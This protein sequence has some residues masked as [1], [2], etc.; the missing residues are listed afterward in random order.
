MAKLGTQIENPTVLGLRRTWRYAGTPSDGAAGTLYNV[1]DIGDLLIDTTGKKL[2][3][4]RGTK[5]SPTWTEVTGSGVA[6]D[7]VVGNMAA[8]G[9]STANA[10]G[11]GPLAA[12]VDHVHKI[13]THDHSDATKGSAIVL[14]ALGAGIFT[15]DATGRA[16]F[17]TNFL[18][19]TKLADIIAI[20]AMTNAFLVAKVA[21]DALDSAFCDAA[22]AANA[23]AA[24][25]AGR[26]PFA[27]G[28]W[29]AAKLA[30]DAVETLKI[31]DLNV[32]TAKLAVGIISADAPGRALFAAG[33]F[34]AATVLSA[35]GTDSF[36]ATAC[37]DVFADNA[38]PSGKVNW[39]YGGV[40]DIVTIVPDASAA[41]GSGAGVARIDHTHAIACATP[42]GSHIADAA[43]AEGSSNSFARADHVHNIATVAPSG[44]C[45]PDAINTEGTADTF[46]R[47]DHVHAMPCAAPSAGLAAADAEGNAVSFARS[48]HVHKAILANQVYFLGRNAAATADINMIK[49]NAS[50][51]VEFGAN[52]AA[53]TLGATLT[54]AAQQ[55]SFS[56]GNI[57]FSGA[58]YVAIG[59]TPA[60]AGAGLRVPNNTYAVYARNAANLADVS[61]IK[62]N[63]SDLVEFGA[64]LAATTMA[65]QLSMAGQALDFTTGYIEFGTSPAAAGALRQ[66][67]NVGIWSARNQAGAGDVVGW[68]VN[69]EN[70]YEAAADVNLGGNSLLGG[71]AANADLNLVATSHATKTTSYIIP[72]QMIDATVNSLAVRVKA[73][74][75]GDAETAQTDL[76]GEVGIDGTNG[77]WYFRYGAA[78]HYCAIT[79]G[80]Q[81]PKEELNCPKCGKLMK[82]GDR[83]EA[84]I[85]EAMSDGA[86]HALWCHAKC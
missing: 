44:D 45:A 30:T 18:D 17:A 28:I 56:T 49:I 25:V 6:I 7:T 15:A 4:N 50:D 42:S 41:T 48:N 58:G 52:L 51:L 20:D 39:S 67:N 10:I 70:D 74:A 63:A 16:K 5:A 66:E 82:I 23:F 60:A 78:W 80:V 59:V 31:K 72:G 84:T 65:G 62:I 1:A 54:A 75:I 34:D 22:F 38:I 76:N 68:K 11:L 43:N 12:P 8:N 57:T 64:S 35:F 61:A 3:Q 81:I 55:I 47:S 40:G 33:V 24:T 79:A 2:Y 32:T 69:A 14:A 19:A 37:A 86:L 85:D 83:V 46:V 71:T 13:G 29:P 73:G 36:D 26:A 77:R 27:D 9:T 21:D 53:T